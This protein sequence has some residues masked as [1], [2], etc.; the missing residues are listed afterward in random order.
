MVLVMKKNC[1]QDQIDAAMKQIENWG[2]KAVSTQGENQTIIGILGD[3]ND[4]LDKPLLA[5]PGVVKKFEV[6]SSYKL[7]SRSFCPMDTVIEVDD[8]KI[9]SGHKA[10]IA[11][12]CSIDTEEI[13]IETAKRVKLA[14]A[15]MFRG[16][17]FKPRTSPYAFQGHGEHG[18]Q[19]L[20]TVKK[21]TGLPTVTELMSTDQIDLVY[22]YV[23]VIQ[24]GAR[25]MQNFNLLK[26]VGKLGKPVIL[27]NSIACVASEQLMSAEYLMANGLKD[28]ILCL[29]GVRSYEKAFRNSLDLTL[30]P[31]LQQVTH[32]P[33][34]IDSSH[35]VGKRDFVMPLAFGGMAMG[36]DGFILEVHPQPAVA[37]SDG[38]QALL[39]D[40]FDMLMDRL[41]DLKVWDQKAYYSNISS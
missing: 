41:Q 22:K 20:E 35:A 10:Y 33:I 19:I 30:I 4:I 14:G 31:Y 29:R 6:S 39:P 17:A 37:L 26:E 2:H 38:D 25:N 12:P 13:A 24:I 40:D 5:I 28:V 9:G 8:V 7:A 34:I 1:S 23:D 36:A 11:G 21:E 27:K 32:L 18:L 3:K 15:N 16:G